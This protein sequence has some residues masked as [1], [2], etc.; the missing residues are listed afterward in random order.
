MNCALATRSTSALR[1]PTR[2]ARSGRK[3]AIAP[4][5]F[6]DVNVVIGGGKRLMKNGME[7]AL[8]RLARVILPSLVALHA[9]PSPLPRGQIAVL[10]Q[11][12]SKGAKILT[13]CWFH[14]RTPHE[15]LCRR[16]KR[17][18]EKTRPFPRRGIT[19][20]FLSAFSLPPSNS[21]CSTYKPSQI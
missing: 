2:Q 12:A 19:S 11:R 13:S 20:R 15:S 7:L 9:S 8:A 17:A 1:A 18:E 3:A 6:S 10:E 4:R 21:L 5:A 14:R 16:R